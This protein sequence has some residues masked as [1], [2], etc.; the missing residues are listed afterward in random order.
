MLEDIQGLPARIA[1]LK[2]KLA[3]REG[4]AEF[5]QNCEAIRE[6]I[7]RLERATQ[8][9]AN[10]QEFVRDNAGVEAEAGASA[11]PDR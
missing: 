3:A 4:K 1:A 2:R 6:E 5:K 7:E 8:S 11:N 9:R 10:L